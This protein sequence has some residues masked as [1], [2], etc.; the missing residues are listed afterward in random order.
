MCMWMYEYVVLEAGGQ[1]KLREEVKVLT[2][3]RS[4]ETELMGHRFRNFRRV[5]FIDCWPRKLPTFFYFYD[6]QRNK[7]LG[8]FF[9]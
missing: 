3:K 6:V 8:I 1:E 9:P 2:L 4:K 5:R 7:T